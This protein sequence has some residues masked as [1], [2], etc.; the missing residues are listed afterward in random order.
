MDDGQ[1]GR[2]GGYEDSSLAPGDWYGLAQRIIVLRRRG[3]TLGVN[4]LSTS[5]TSEIYKMRINVSWLLSMNT[6]FTTVVCTEVM[7]LKKESRPEQE[8]QT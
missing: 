7:W 6:Y 5:Q 3:Q 8:T 4:H 1:S 2:L